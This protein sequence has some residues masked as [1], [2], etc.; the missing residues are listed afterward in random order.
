M[1]PEENERERERWKNRMIT[2]KARKHVC[3]FY[4]STPKLLTWV[5]LTFA[6]GNKVEDIMFHLEH[7][8]GLSVN[9]SQG[10]S[11]PGPV[12]RQSPR[13]YH[14]IFPAPHTTRN[15]NEKAHTQNITYHIV[16]II[17]NSHGGK[18][19][20]AILKKDALCVIPQHNN[21]APYFR[22][23]NVYWRSDYQEVGC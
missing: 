21:N 6:N 23:E 3:F 18:G 10:W 22:R 9:H 4:I 2:K 14:K 19:G 5:P 20:N 15:K 17:I 12:C 16:I 1:C 13:K 7:G 8:S 11:L